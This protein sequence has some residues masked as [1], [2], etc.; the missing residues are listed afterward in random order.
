MIKASNGTFADLSVVNCVLLSPCTHPSYLIALLTLYEVLPEATCWLSPVCSC[1]H[2]L[3][4]E[5]YV[6]LPGTWLDWFCLL[7]AT[8]P[9]KR[10][11]AHSVVGA[12]Q[13]LPAWHHPDWLWRRADHHLPHEEPHV[14]HPDHEE[15]T[16]TCKPLQTLLRV[17]GNGKLLFYIFFKC[18]FS[19]YTNRTKCQAQKAKER[20]GYFH[21]CTNFQ[22]L[23]LNS[24]YSAS[25]SDFA[26][27]FSVLFPCYGFCLKA[28]SSSYSSCA[29]LPILWVRA[30]GDGCTPFLPSFHLDHSE[31]LHSMCGLP[32][33]SEMSLSGKGC[34]QMFRYIHNI[35][36]D[37]RDPWPNVRNNIISF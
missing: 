24:P 6:H 10:R 5:N 25:F 8:S 2:H 32:E 18:L 3:R 20:S 35:F 29:L 4:D 13:G 15:T 11:G 12:Q 7:A 23:S 22:A 34:L 16:G 33:D 30:L 28:L 36:Y 37:F 27:R 9:G 17:I 1:H 21:H 19:F 31:V 14:F 26:M